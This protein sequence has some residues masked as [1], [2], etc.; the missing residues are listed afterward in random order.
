MRLYRV[1]NKLFAESYNGQGASFRDGARWNNKGVPVLYF[2]MSPS[3]A[4]LELA[5]Y[6]PTPRLLPKN[7]VM[8]VYD[9][10]GDIGVERVDVSKLSNDWAD[11]PY[12]ISAQKIGTEFLTSCKNLALEVPSSAVT[13]GLESILVVNP[14]HPDIKKI[15]LIET[16][17][18]IYNV[19]AFKGV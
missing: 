6:L 1:T 12:P 9:V 8:C 16:H 10:S 13:A 5:N 4:M 17:S 19:R 15:K 14:L 7:T 11:F 18:E 3:T 2:A